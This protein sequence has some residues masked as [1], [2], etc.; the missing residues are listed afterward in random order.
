MLNL[1]LS[2]AATYVSV[3]DNFILVFFFLINNLTLLLKQ[4]GKIEKKKQNPK[5]VEGNKS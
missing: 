4:L 1:E 2:D 3:L 5:L